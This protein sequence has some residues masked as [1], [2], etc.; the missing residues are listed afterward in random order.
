MVKLYVEKRKSA[1]WAAKARFQHSPLSDNISDCIRF[2]LAYIVIVIS[3]IET[4]PA[5]YF[6]TFKLMTKG[7][8][9]KAEKVFRLM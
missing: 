6:T 4:L 9:R 3:L 8:P 2:S 1:T 5:E 7:S